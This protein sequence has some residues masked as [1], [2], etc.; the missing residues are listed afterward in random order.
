MV[1]PSLSV[2]FPTPMS[3]RCASKNHQA[4]DDDVDGDY[5]DDDNDN[6]DGEKIQ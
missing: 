3:Q 1:S 2:N 4:D 5:G 6:E